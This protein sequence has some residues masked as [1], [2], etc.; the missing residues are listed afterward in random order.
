MQLEGLQTAS[1]HCHGRCGVGDAQ[2]AGGSSISWDAERPEG[3]CLS[4]HP[5]ANNLLQNLCEFGL[6]SP[7][8]GHSNQ[9][10]CIGR[11]GGGDDFR[12]EW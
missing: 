11:M 5:C 2:G 9:G 1:E 3:C 4:D 8:C 6:R 12:E 7:H 10:F